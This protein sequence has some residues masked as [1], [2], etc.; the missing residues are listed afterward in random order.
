MLWPDPPMCCIHGPNVHGRERCQ[1]PQCGCEKDLY[2]TQ[3]Q[4]ALQAAAGRKPASAPPPP[5]PLDYRWRLIAHLD[6]N[7]EIEINK[8]VF[9]DDE[10]GADIA[11]R[12]V[13]RTAAELAVAEPAESDDA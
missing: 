7:L 1:A 3:R 12:E 11:L 10:E 9:G 2:L 5:D 8:E 6:G 13:Q 4:L